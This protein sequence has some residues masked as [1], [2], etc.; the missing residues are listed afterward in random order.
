MQFIYRAL[1]LSTRV[2]LQDKDILDILSF[3]YMQWVYRVRMFQL[4]NR[5]NYCMTYVHNFI[6]LNKS[7]RLLNIFLYNSI[8]TLQRRKINQSTGPALALQ[9]SKNASPLQ[10]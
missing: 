9:N 6:L 8:F 4:R 5:A 7:L 10:S 1:D 2:V 3:F